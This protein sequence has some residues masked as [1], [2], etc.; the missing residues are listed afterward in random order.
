M[1]A[2]FGSTAT[3]LALAT[4]SAASFLLVENEAA[5]LVVGLAAVAIALGK[6]AFILNRFM[7]LE[8][9]HRPF[10]QVLAV[11]LGAVALILGGGLYA[12]PWP[13]A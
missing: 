3:L 8:W 1:T 2:R 5:S 7:H 13:P 11:W 10:A 6:A 4:L 9:H 12:L